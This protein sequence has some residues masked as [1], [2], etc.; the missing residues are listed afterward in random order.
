[1]S[2]SGGMG[3]RTIDSTADDW[4]SIVQE[5]RK[6]ESPLMR[7]TVLAG[8]ARLSGSFLTTSAVLKIPWTEQALTLSW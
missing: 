4:V 6:D 1:M 8:H 5:A 7:L 3:K 2:S